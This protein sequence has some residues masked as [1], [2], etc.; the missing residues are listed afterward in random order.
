MSVLE[1]SAGTGNLAVFARMAGGIVETNEIDPRRSELLAMQGLPVTNIDAERLHNLLDPG[2]TFDAIVM[3]P[4]I[5]AT[6]GR[7]T[8]HNTK[9][10]ARDNVHDR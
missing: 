8:G 3:N 9:F 7:V 10:G 4:P 5:S 6:G 1:P 2:K